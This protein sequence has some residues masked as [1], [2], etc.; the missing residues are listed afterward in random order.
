MAGELT[1]GSPHPTTRLALAALAERAADRVL[2]VGTGDGVL[3]RAA[4]AAGA[5][6]VVG[7]D[8]RAVPAVAGATMLQVAVEAYEGGGFDVVVA[9]LPDP[10]LLAVLPRLAAMGRTLLVTGVRV[11]RAAAL[12]VRLAAAGA[13]IAATRAREGWV[14]YVAEA[15]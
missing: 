5:T 12:R 9:N 6:E 8:V 13:R 15:R 3:A 14:L 4:L 2:D 1:E 7:I 11:E 10:V